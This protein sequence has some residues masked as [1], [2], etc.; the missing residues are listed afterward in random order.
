MYLVAIKPIYARLGPALI[1]IINDGSLTSIDRT[2]LNEHLGDIKYLDAAK[3]NTGRCPCGGTW[4]RLLAILELSS[5]FYVLQVD[6]DIVA[7]GDLVA[8]AECVHENRA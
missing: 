5:D 4:E 7:L 1:T 6:A 3:I 2:L 8:V